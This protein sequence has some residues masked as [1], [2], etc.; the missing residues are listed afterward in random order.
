MPQG[1]INATSDGF[2]FVLIMPVHP[3]SAWSFFSQGVEVYD[4]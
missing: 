1:A 4:N 2:A 3:I